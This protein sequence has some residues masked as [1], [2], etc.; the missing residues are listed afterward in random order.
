MIHKILWHYVLAAIVRLQPDM[1][2][3]GGTPPRGGYIS[4]GKAQRDVWGGSRAVS[5]V[6]EGI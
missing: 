3:D 6:Q 1:V 2:V 5:Q 4:V